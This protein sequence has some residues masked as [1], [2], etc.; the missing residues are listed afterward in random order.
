MIIAVD[1]D[2]TI[3]EHRYPKIGKDFAA[4]IRGEVQKAMPAAYGPMQ[5]RRT[6][7]RQDGSGKGRPKA[8]A[9]FARPSGSET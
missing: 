2:G 6:G 3:V 4:S 1:F 9:A 7:S 5:A 8:T